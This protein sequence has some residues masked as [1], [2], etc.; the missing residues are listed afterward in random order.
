MP[1]LGSESAIPDQELREG[2]YKL[3]SLV[4]RVKGL[5]RK[6]VQQKDETLMEGFSQ[7]QGVTTQV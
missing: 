1:N 5:E 2:L 4:L 3:E 7:L 6:V